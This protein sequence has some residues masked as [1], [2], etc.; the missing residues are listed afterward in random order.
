MLLFLVSTLIVIVW[1][2]NKR[3]EGFTDGSASR[4]VD[5]VDVSPRGVDR[6][7][8]DEVVE[9]SSMDTLRRWMVTP[10]TEPSAESAFTAEGELAS[11]LP[12]I[13]GKSRFGYW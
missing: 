5:V 1:Y 7:R 6:V 11:A 9:A 2:L 4:P 3:G 12:T 13:P 8:D 10:F